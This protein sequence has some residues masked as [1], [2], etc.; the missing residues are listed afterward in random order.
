MDKQNKKILKAVPNRA[1]QTAA[2]YHMW[3]KTPSSI[4]AKSG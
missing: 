2:C 3:G 4:S 1:I